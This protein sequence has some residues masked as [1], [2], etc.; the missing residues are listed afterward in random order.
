[1]LVL[2]YVFYGAMENDGVSKALERCE[3]IEMKWAGFRRNMETVIGGSMHQLQPETSV[4][5]RNATKADMGLNLNDYNHLV[6]SKDTI[7]KD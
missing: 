3:S 5:R 6:L 1:M 4:S 7:I 2:L